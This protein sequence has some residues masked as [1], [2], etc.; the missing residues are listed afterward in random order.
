MALTYTCKQFTSSPIQEL[1]NF[2]TNSQDPNV[3]RYALEAMKKICKKYRY[4]F[5]S[6]SLYSEMNYMIEHLSAHLLIQANNC[7]EM[8]KQAGVDKATV[9][10]CLSIMNSILHIMESILS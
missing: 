3:I 4:M 1:I 10:V 8:A 7:M 6:D 5:R 9:E 2:L